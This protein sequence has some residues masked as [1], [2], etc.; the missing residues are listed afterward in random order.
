MTGSSTSDDN[1]ITNGRV[2]YGDIENMVREHDRLLGFHTHGVLLRKLHR[3][4]TE[5]E[6]LAEMYRLLRDRVTP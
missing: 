1:V 6:F 4:P 2:L 3:A 5:D